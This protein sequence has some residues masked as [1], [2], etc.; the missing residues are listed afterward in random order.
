MDS[1]YSGSSATQPGKDKVQNFALPREDCSIML[2]HQNRCNLLNL[3]GS[4]KSMSYHDLLGL[5]TWTTTKYIRDVN[6]QSVP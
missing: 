1:V 6:C 4:V 5:K 3:T 2:R